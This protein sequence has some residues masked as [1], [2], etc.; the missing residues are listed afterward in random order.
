MVTDRF[1]FDRLIQKGGPATTGG[2]TSP[3]AL[4]DEVKDLAV[5]PSELPITTA[6]A[7]FDVDDVEFERMR[8]RDETLTPALLRE[9]NYFLGSFESDRRVA[10]HLIERNKGADALVLFR[11]VDKM[12]HAALDKSE[13]VENHLKVPPAEVSRFGRAVTQAYRDADR[14]IG[15]LAA[16]FGDSNVIVVSDHGFQLE[17]PHPE[18]AAHDEDAPNTI[19]YRHA[20]APPGIF[21]AAGPAFRPGAVEGISI[22]DVLPML[23]YLKGFPTAEDQK[24]RVPRDAFDAAFLAAHGELRIATYGPH[25]AERVAH[26]DAAVDVEVTERLRAL[27][28]IRY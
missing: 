23:L 10:R 18:R 9:F 19:A 6:R 20:D 24:G 11:L 3:D 5:L 17:H 7:Y 13:L 27:G 28:Y 12:C 1:Y 21:L 4:F 26:G 2:L 25:E 22:Y 14:A 15:E 8:R 16:G